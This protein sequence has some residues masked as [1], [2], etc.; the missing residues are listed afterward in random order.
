MTK[1]KVIFFGNG[2]LAETV[3]NALK[4]NVEIIF[5]AKQK[6]DL[7]QTIQIMKNKEQKVYGV[8]ASFG[9]II[10]NSVLELFEPEGIINVHP[11]YLPDLRGPSPI[12]TAMLRG[13]T[14]F[15]VSVMKLV[16]KMDAGPIYYQEKIAMDKFAQ[17]SEIYERLGECGGK[18]VAENLTQLPKPVEQNGEATYSKMLDT[19]MARLRPVEQT[20]EEMLDQI[21]AF[22]HFPKTRIEVKG[23]D[24]I[25]LS[26]HLSNEPEPIKGHTELSLK[27]KDGLYLIIDEIQP[28]G[29]KAMG[30]AAFANGYLK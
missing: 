10:P 3:F 5:C 4:D 16:E 29:K 11:S 30:A 17:K 1:P 28:A 9:V 7:E 8:L 6:E 23:L 19:K 26:A 12:E 24:C 14:E 25:V 13:D 27:G 20:A 18:W 2:L 15:G 22:M 21:R